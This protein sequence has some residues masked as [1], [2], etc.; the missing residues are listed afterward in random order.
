GGGG[1]GP[2]PPRADELLDQFG[3][4]HAADRAA[5]TYSGGML[6]RLHL[7]ASL[8][9]SPP[10]LFLDEPTTGLDP[11]S[12]MDMWS[13]VRELVGNGTTVL[14]TTQYLDEA[15][16]LADHI[17]VM[18]AGHV[19]A[20]GSP[21]TLKAAIGGR[22]DVVAAEEQLADAAR[23]MEVLTG[24][25]PAVDRAGRLISTPTAR[26]VTLPDVVRALDA[27]G[28]TAEDIT[29]RRPT[30]DEVFLTLTDRT[31]P[32]TTTGTHPSESNAS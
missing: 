21:D 4:D 2:P 9:V 10:L 7:M 31:S 24:G 8:I 19:V 26:P 6:R 28:V 17:A 11:R 14:L 22:V 27:A 25:R 5:G 16:R 20:T 15:D 1:A 32:D 23:A 30:L 13:A 18:D 3:L 12:R 29:M